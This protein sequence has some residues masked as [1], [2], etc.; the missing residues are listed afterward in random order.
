MELVTVLVDHLKVDVDGFEILGVEQ[1]EDDI[2]IKRIVSVSKPVQ[3]HHH[4]YDAWTFDKHLLSLMGP[5]PTMQQDIQCW[6]VAMTV[7][8]GK[9]KTLEFFHENRAWAAYS[10]IKAGLLLT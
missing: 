3:G 5:D 1:V 4:I 7:D 6:R 9:E 8:N 2:V 10:A